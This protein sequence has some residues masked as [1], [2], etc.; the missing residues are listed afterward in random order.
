VPTQPG[1][2][3]TAGSTPAA[4]AR[5]AAPR[6]RRAGPDLSLA[7]GGAAGRQRQPAGGG[8]ALGDLLDREL[9]QGPLV[10]HLGAR[11]QGQAQH[12]V[13]QVHRLP[14]RAGPGLGEGHV[15]QQQAAVVHQQVGRLDV[16]VGQAGIYSLR[17]ILRPSSITCWSTLS[18]QLGRAVE[19]LVD[20][21]VLPV[22]SQLHKAVRSWSGQAGQVQLVQGIVLL[23]PSRRTVL[24]SF[25]S[26]SRPYSSSRPA[27]TSGRR[28]GGF[29]RTA[30]RTGRHPGRPVSSRVA[31]GILTPRL[32][33]I[34]A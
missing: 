6:T 32:P 16:T 21:Q 23:L 19:E 12:H 17:M 34:R 11:A 28:G 2:R 31:G 3:F 1:S 30:C 8:E 18:P 25:S 26:S 13:G 7:A 20:Q 14:P 24:N 4:A 33:Q 10:D 9:A 22:R 27:C 5:E 29:W 15:D